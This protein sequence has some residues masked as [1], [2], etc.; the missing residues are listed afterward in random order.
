[1]LVLRATLIV[2]CK[3]RD[4]KSHLHLLYIF[5]D[6]NMVFP[7]MGGDV[8]TRQGYNCPSFINLSLL[9]PFAPLSGP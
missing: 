3:F 6:V 1:M 5:G 2:V 7:L 9:S 4:V 8:T